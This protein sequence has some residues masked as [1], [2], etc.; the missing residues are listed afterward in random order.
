MKEHEIKFSDA[1]IINGQVVESNIRMIKQS[2]ISKCPFYILMPSHYRADGTCKC[3]D[4]MERR[5]MCKQWGYTKRDFVRA[6]IIEA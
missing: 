5:M 2:D 6:G 4:A 3:N 1:T